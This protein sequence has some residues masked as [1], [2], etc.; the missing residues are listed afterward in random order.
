M[1]ETWPIPLSWGVSAQRFWAA[2]RGIA[3]SP[4]WLCSSL[5]PW[6]Q[7]FIT[8]NASDFSFDFVDIEEGST[9]KHFMGF[10]N[11]VSYTK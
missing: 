2:K 1:S 7:L 3:C 11:C 8:T 10:R 6:H 9:F 5:S 4:L